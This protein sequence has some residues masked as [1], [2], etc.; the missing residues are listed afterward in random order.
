MV[1]LQPVTYINHKTICIY[2]Y[3]FSFAVRASIYPWS[4]SQNLP[5]SKRCRQINRCSHP[6][7]AQYPHKRNPSVQLHG[8]DG[9]LVLQESLRRAAWRKCG[10]WHV[11]GSFHSCVKEAIEWG[12]LC[13]SWDHG[14]PWTR[15]D[16]VFFTN[17]CPRVHPLH[18]NMV[19]GLHVF[20]IAKS[21]SDFI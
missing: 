16:L 18:Q 14:W 11:W 1:R 4:W 21:S 7:R 17:Q 19:C 10:L 3:V 9:Q 5:I 13:I 2:I 6:H 20:T 15:D 8:S 12:S